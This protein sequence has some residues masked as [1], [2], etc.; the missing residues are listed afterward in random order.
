MQKPTKRGFVSVEKLD[1]ETLTITAYNETI[2]VTKTL[3]GSIESMKIL[4]ECLDS[5]LEA[6]E[7]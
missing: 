7:V 1:D 3:I 2:D 6:D 4:R 5:V